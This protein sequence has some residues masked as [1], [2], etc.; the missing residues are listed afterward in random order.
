MIPYPGFAVQRLAKEPARRQ[1]GGQQSE[2]GT[3]KAECQPLERQ[4]RQATVVI[5]MLAHLAFCARHQ[6]RMH[7]RRSEQTVGRNAER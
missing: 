6:R 2:P 3:Y 1:G 5:A 7:D 4:Q